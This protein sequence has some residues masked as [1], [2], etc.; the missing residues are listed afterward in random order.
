MT[1]P[2]LPQGRA[3]WTR[4]ALAAGLC[5]RRHPRGSCASSMTPARRGSPC[6]QQTRASAAEWGGQPLLQQH[7]KP[8]QCSYRIQGQEEHPGRRGT[9]MPQ[10]QR[11]PKL[12]QGQEPAQDAKARRHAQIPGERQ[13]EHCAGNQPPGPATDH[14]VEGDQP[15]GD[16]KR[17]QQVTVLLSVLRQHGKPLPA[18]AFRGFREHSRGVSRNHPAAAAARIYGM[19]PAAGR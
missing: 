13:A 19:I 8:Q 3:R 1:R 16:D 2:A 11:R 6:P 15:G 12:K 10:R 7:E 14:A 9:R 4:G 17:P 5:P 18:T